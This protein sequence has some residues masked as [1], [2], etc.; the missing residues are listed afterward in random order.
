MKAILRKIFSIPGEI[1]TPCCCPICGN[2]SLDR[3][4]NMF[5]KECLES[6]HFVKSPVCPKCGGEHNGILEEC[7]ECLNMARER[8]WERATALFVM[9]GS[10]KEAIYQFKYRSNLALAR[11]F[12]SLGSTLLLE[13]NGK[14]DFITF[15]PLH[16]FRYLKRGYN[17]SA[18]LGE[19]LGREMKLPAKGV[20]YRKKHTRRQASLNREERL[21]NMKDSFSILPFRKEFCK[22]KNILLIDDVM[23]SGA[24]LSAATEALLQ[25]GAA[26]VSIFVIARRQKE[27]N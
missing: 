5:C 9:T 8:P 7:G 13:N 25:A 3:S 14:W 4:Q 15:V 20:L 16:P 18:I 26:K 10:V 27:Y 21:K 24:T 22:G 11:T 23:T 12:A 2:A 17:Q 19:M 6:F 1:L